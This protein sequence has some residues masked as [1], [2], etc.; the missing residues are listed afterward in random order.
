[1]RDATPKRKFTQSIELIMNLKD[2]DMKKPDSRIQ[3][4]IEVPHQLT[5]DVK[6]C[7]F[8][9]GDLALRA[10][11]GGADR[12]INRDELETIAKDKKSAK[13]LVNDYAHFIAE[14]PIMP[15]IGKTLGTYMGP[16]GKMPTPIPPAAPIEDIISRHRKTI[17]IRIRDQPTV[18][19]RFA[20]EDM[21]DEKILENLSTIITGVES[22]LT[23]GDKNVSI[24]RLKATMG[25][26]VKIGA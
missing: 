3:T 23:R 16:R 22:K 8:A 14:A 1:M 21:P 15:L 7:V 26:P 20:T 10:K 24:I 18:K 11:K 6:I 2:I 25:K 13:K 5:K 17:K 12:V 9:T 19:C 4:Q